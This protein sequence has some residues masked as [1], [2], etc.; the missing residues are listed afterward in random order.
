MKHYKIPIDSDHYEIFF[1]AI[2]S[3][4]D[5]IKLLMNTVKYATTELRV[6]GE[7]KY[8]LHIIVDDMNRFIYESENKIFSVRSP[9]RVM[10]NENELT[11]YTAYIAN[12]DNAITSNV[13]SMLND[14]KFDSPNSFDFLGLIEESFELDIDD[15]WPFIIDLISFEDGYL[16][17]DYD[18]ENEKDRLHP[19][20]HLDICYTTASTYKIGTYKK[21]CVNYLTS[22]L[23]NKVDALYLER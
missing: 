12:I 18:P 5:V 10:G 15:V 19:L 13:L 22:L 11:F 9:F 4:K 16:R 8:Y 23:N 7:H 20:S 1:G 14:E 17:Y 2:R 21:P 3:K 6:T